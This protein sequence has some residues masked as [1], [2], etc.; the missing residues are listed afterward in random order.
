MPETRRE[1]LERLAENAA[2][3]VAVVGGGING[4]GTYRELAMQGL[5]VLLVERADFCSGCSAAPSRMI[6]GGLRYLE[7]GE[8]SLVRESLRER[9]ALLKN[10]PHLVK[11]LPTTVPITSTFSGLW[12]G[13]ASFLGSEQKPA[14]RGALPIKIGLSLYD[15]VTRRR[16][17]LPRHIFHSAKEARK[18]WPELRGD[19]RYAATYHD[20]WISYPERL[21]LE[22][23]SDTEALSPESLA[24]NYAS[25]LP[26]GD[27]GYLLED[28]ESGEQIPLRT[29]AVVNA[30][31]AWLDETL[32]TLA[33]DQRPN[34]RMVSGTKGSH[35]IIANEELESAL[36]GHMIFYENGDGRI[37]I[38]FPYLGNVL[39]GA[40]DIRVSEVTSV[41]CEEHE[42]DYILESIRSVFPK[43]Q[44][45]ADQIVFSFSG[46]RPLPKSNDAFTGRISRSHNVRR[47]SGPLPVFCMIGGKWTTFRAFAEQAT[48]QVLEAL[49][50][51]RLRNSLETAIGGGAEKGPDLPATCIHRA[52]HLTDHYGSHAGRIES[53]CSRD[54]TD[55]PLAPGCRYTTAEIE[56]LIRQ[57]S[58]VHLN[59]VLLRR[60]SLAITGQISSA[61]IHRVAGIAARVLDWSDGRRDEE[62]GRVRQELKDLFGVTATMLDARDQ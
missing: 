56:F 28:M 31:G 42:R 24:L 27:G 15:F 33:P 46:I 41:R 39:V 1:K 23:I 54:E 12:N 26:D 37:C 38:M 22:L 51:P 55:A 35:L 57:E 11:P 29:K 6:H 30:T 61:I 44:V 50:K 16:R 32:E 48:D 7:N 40:T 20:A 25:L 10:A 52:R 18:R 59:D 19:I 43:I 9:D 36:D 5:R 62:I 4:I 49:E 2:F 47:L 53:F 17:L 3:D 21:A 58:V 14:T 13:A 8:F 45:Q 60:T 34:H